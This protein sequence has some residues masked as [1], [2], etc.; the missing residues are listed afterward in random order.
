M[1]LSMGGLIAVNAATPAAPNSA[2]EQAVVSYLEAAE[3]ELMAIGKQVNEVIPEDADAEM[4]PS[5]EVEKLVK[6]WDA[7]LEKWA[8]LSKARQSNFDSAKMAYEKQR[9]VVRA[10]LADVP[11]ALS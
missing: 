4:A 6:A 5:F 7:L 2:Y 9:S 11:A 10:A 1:G 8:V 3:A